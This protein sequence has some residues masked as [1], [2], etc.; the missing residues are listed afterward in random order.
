MST[1]EE[2]SAA[3]KVRCPR[4]NA[5]PFFSCKRHTKT[6]LIFLKVPHAERIQRGIADEGA[7]S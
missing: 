4:C 2:K 5:Q 6:K 7:G 1:A 3:R